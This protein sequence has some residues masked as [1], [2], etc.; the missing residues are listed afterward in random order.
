MFR[1][2]WWNN[3]RYVRQREYYTER[4]FELYLLKAYNNSVH[5]SRMNSDIII[6]AYVVSNGEWEQLKHKNGITI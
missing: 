5:P 3:N 2:E 4:N 1:I 6:K